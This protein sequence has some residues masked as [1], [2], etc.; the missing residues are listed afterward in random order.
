[1]TFDQISFMLV[2]WFDIWTIA[3]C[4][5]EMFCDNDLEHYL[6][7]ERRKIEKSLNKGVKNETKK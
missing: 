6:Q 3:M 1:M 4:F 7:R 2:F 5:I